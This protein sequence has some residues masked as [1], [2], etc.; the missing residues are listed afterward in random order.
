MIEVTLEL[1]LQL[2]QRDNI[3]LISDGLSDDE[4]IFYKKGSGICYEDGALIGR[5]WRYAFN[6][7][8]RMD[9]TRRSRFYIVGKE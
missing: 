4:Y 7:L 2:V 3:K 8:D 9:W 6:F 5:N 1:G